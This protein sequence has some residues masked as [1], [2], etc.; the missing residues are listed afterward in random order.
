MFHLVEIG[1]QLRSVESKGHGDETMKCNCCEEEI[2]KEKENEVLCQDCYDLAM[3]ELEST[4]EDLREELGCAKIIICK[5]LTEM[6][7]DLRKDI[8][9][10]KLDIFKRT[11]DSN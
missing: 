7:E 5:L 6:G 2:V 9:R 1:A 3:K 10:Q 8:T 4:I 11:R